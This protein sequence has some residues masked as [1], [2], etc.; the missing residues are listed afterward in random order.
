MALLHR[1]FPERFKPVNDKALLDGLE[2]WLLPMLGEATGPADITARAVCGG[3][4]LYVGY[5]LLKE[6][7]RLVPRTF[8]L[9]SGQ[10]HRLDYG[11]ESVTLRARVQEFYGLTQHPA[12]CDGKVAAIVELLSPAMRPIQ[13]TLDLAGFWSGSWQDVRKEMRGRYPKHF[14]PQEPATAQATTRTKPKR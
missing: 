4:K 8:H 7:D 10:S 12:I 2:E 11:P 14:W 9:P 5:G 13:T 3:L 1:E 6:M